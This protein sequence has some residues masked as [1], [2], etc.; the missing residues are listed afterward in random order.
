MAL[1]RIL[2]F[3]VA[4]VVVGTVPST[5]QLSTDGNQLWRQGAGGILDVSDEDD[6][7]GQALAAGDFNGDGWDDL[8][9]GALGENDFRGAVNIIY[10]GPGGLTAAGNQL[11]EQGAG[12]IV[13]NA[14]SADRLGVTVAAGD[15]NGDG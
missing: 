8:A 15:F 7:F 13:G 11:W 4:A 10:G 9:I 2:C 14:E 5:A 12:G 6:R 3:G 1:F